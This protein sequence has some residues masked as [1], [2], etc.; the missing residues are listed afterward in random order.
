M[1]FAIVEIFK[2]LQGEGSRTGEP[3]IFVRFAG[4]NLWNGNKNSRLKGSGVCSMWCDTFFAKGTAYS[5]KDLVKE[6][7]KNA[8]KKTSYEILPLVVL[9]GGEPMLQLKNPEGYKFV[10]ELLTGGFKV[11]LETNG[12]VNGPVIKL[13]NRF[14]NGHVT[15]SPKP[16]KGK[17]DDY[18]H[19]KVR[20]GEDLKVIYPTEFKLTDLR[21]WKF[22]H[23]YLQPKDEGPDCDNVSSTISR[24]TED[25]WKVSIQTHKLLGLP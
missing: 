18:E 12:T 24:A 25:G 23:H 4:C 11:A 16:L 21:K 2:T 1:K 19:V 6:I 17:L 5:T 13:L 10:E 15:V 3:A 20:T 9:T 8:A 22:N 7:K 14:S